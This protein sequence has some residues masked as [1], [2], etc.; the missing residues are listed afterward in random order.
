MDVCP[1][2]S[3]VKASSTLSLCSFA[4]KGKA[5]TPARD[6]SRAGRLDEMQAASFRGPAVRFLQRCRSHS[7]APLW[8]QPAARLSLL[9]T[10]SFE[11]RCL[12]HLRCLD[13]W[14]RCCW[15]CKSLPSRRLR[16]PRHYL[17]PARSLAQTSKTLWHCRYSYEHAG[18]SLRNTVNYQ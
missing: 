14:R 1:R 7:L 13:C 15:H 9:H 2:M 4:K 3:L 6:R 8:P 12:R 17:K 5:L 18:T 16:R 10:R 11:A